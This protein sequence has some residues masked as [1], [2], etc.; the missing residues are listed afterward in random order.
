MAQAVPRTADPFAEQLDYPTSPSAI[1]SVYA[2]SSQRMALN[3]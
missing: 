3:D 2:N 1:K